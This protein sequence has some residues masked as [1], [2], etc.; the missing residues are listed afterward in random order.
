MESW[1]CGSY[2]GQHG[3][4]EQEFPAAAAYLLWSTAERHEFEVVMWRECRRA[5]WARHANWDASHWLTSRAVTRE[6]TAALAA[7]GGHPRPRGPGRPRRAD[8]PAPALRR[9]AERAAREA[10]PA[11]AVPNSAALQT[12]A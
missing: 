5:E 2:T 10:G 6:V 7:S 1:L 12:T 11:D 8:R 3:H 9:G 4:P